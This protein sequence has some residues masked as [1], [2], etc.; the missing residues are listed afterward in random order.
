MQNV[1]SYEVP[2]S[3]EGAEGVSLRPGMTAN[4]SIVVGRQENVLLLPALAVQQGEEGNVVIVQD[5]PQGP[6]EATPVE[7]GLSDGMYVEVLRGL[8]EGDRVVVEYQSQEQPGGFGGFGG[9]IH[10]PGGIPGMT[11]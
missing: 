10:S 6:T 8:N 4:L 11:R 9:M 3:L 2:V 5:T 1:V 7:V